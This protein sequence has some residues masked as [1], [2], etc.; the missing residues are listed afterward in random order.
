MDISLLDREAL[1]DIVDAND[2]NDKPAETS[3]EKELET[4]LQDKIQKG[5]LTLDNM[6][7][8]TNDESDGLDE[9][10]SSE[11]MAA[12]GGADAIP[13]DFSDDEEE[14]VAAPEEEAVDVVNPNDEE[15]VS[16]CIL[17]KVFLGNK[18]VATMPTF[19]DKGIPTTIVDI[20][21]TMAQNYQKIGACTIRGEA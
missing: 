10:L 20:P 1:Q 6:S 3:T 8:M 2:W 17:Q 14:V 15:L 4:Y 9:S 13:D 16:V 18:G 5:E 12:A 19:C 11:I 21:L 7:D